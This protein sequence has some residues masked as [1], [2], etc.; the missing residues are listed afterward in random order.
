M[1]VKK[2][3]VI[4]VQSGKLVYREIIPVAL[5]SAISSLVLVPLVFL[6]PLG[7]ALV[8]LPLIYVPLCTGVL[9]A[10]H[11]LLEGEKFQIRAI[12]FGAR[13]CYGASV[14]FA[15]VCSLFALIL[16]SSWWYY[17]NK[18]GAFYFALAVFQTYFVAMFF[19]SQ[20]YALP[21][22]IQERIGIFRAMGKSFKLF[23]AHPLYTIGAFVQIVC[24]TLV[25]GVTVVGFACLYVGMI[26]MYA[27]L[28]TA[29]VLPQ[30]E[31]DSGIGRGAEGDGDAPGFVQDSAPN[32]DAKLRSGFGLLYREQ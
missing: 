16:V 17:G 1:S 29:N 12:F 19:V 11:R 28:V 15:L 14:V 9:Y 20:I 31:T 4:V 2:L 21:L 18:Q 5:S 10:C 30:P 32:R 26:A 23:V 25:L 24:L 22:V 3:S 13:K 6:L 7:W 27:N 8:L